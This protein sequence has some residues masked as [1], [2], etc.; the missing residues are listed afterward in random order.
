[1][2]AAPESVREIIRDSFLPMIGVGWEA[3]SAWEA[4]EYDFPG[5]ADLGLDEADYAE[6][7]EPYIHHFPDGNASVARALVRDLDTTSA[8][9]LW[10]GKPGDCASWIILPWDATDSDVRIRLNSTVVRVQNIG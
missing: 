10:N 4:K 2:L 6:K 9:R 5:T 3:A 7:E 1:M 8:T